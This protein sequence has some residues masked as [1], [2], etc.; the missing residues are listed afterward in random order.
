[1]SET[2]D[3]SHTIEISRKG[4]FADKIVF[5][6]GQPG[7]GKTMLASIVAALDKAELLTYSYEIELICMMRYLG[8]IELD[9]AS[10]AVGLHTDLAL[11]NLMMSREVN[12]RI[13]DLSSIFS[14]AYP[15][16]YIKRLFMK[17]DEHVPGRIRELN[18]ILTLTTHLLTGMSESIFS[19]LGDR[20]VFIEGVR[21]PAYMVRQQ[22]LNME[23]LVRNPRDFIIYHFYK[24]KDYPFWA[25]GW[26]EEFDQA[27][28]VEKA[29]LFIK[30]VSEWTNKTR[31]KVRD[32]YGAKII[33]VPFESFVLDP[34]PYLDEMCQCLGTRVTSVTRKAMKRQRVPRAKIADGI[35]LGIY[36][37][38]GW[39]P[40]EKNSD[41]RKELDKRMAYVRD[42][43]SDNIYQDFKKLSDDYQNTY[44]SE[45]AIERV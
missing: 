22:E 31:K 7:C 6:D 19:Q 30:H 38:C 40:G 20:V 24:G 2:V 43:V 34:E 28:A 18:P 12:F 39:E 8:R 35:G 4:F 13:G 41:E 9:A 15:W 3:Q 23:R 17:G 14:S 21:H 32:Q 26:E 25:R 11:Y 10:A 33:T 1:M 37:R 42:R 5:I 16:R 45:L 29:A 44:W 27:N 36:K